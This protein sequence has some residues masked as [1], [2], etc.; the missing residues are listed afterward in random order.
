MLCVTMNNNLFEND[1]NLWKDTFDKDL[2][3]IKKTATR[4]FVVVFAVWAAWAIFSLA[5][6]GGVIYVAWHFISKFW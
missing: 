1:S 3:N 4:G 6:L 5:L 2:A